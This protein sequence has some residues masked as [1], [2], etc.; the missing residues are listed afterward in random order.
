MSSSLFLDPHELK[1]TEFATTEYRPLLKASLA[2]DYIPNSVTI[3]VN[4]TVI[5][6]TFLSNAQSAIRINIY[7]ILFYFRRFMIQKRQ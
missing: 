1:E 6:P 2:L 5:I 3:P 7:F 4:T